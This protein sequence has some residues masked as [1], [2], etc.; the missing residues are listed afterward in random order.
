MTV[1]PG[2][3][4]HENKREQVKLPREQDSSEDAE[5]PLLLLHLSKTI[6]G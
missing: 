1:Q 5:P 4:T 3:L 6:N 2:D